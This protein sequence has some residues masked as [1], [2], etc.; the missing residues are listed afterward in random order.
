MATVSAYD[1]HLHTGSVSKAGHC[2]QGGR[3]TCARRP[4]FSVVGDS[5]NVGACDEH[6]A[7]AVRQ[8][9]AMPRRL[10]PS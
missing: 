7:G 4:V 9:N 1:A 8:A 2:G 3:D 10:S 5:Y 6:L